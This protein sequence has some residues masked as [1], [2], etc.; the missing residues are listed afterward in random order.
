MFILDIFSFICIVLVDVVLN[1][2]FFLHSY[3][4]DLADI[5]CVNSEAN[6]LPSTIC[7]SAVDR[8]KLKIF[9]STFTYLF[10]ILINYNIS[11]SCSKRRFQN[12]PYLI[13][14]YL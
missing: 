1:I 8:R 7:V 9:V 4:I 11:F 10:S 5:I 6:A 13:I 14:I 3:N 2:I 12:I